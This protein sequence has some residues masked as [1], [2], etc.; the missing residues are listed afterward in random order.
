MRSRFAPH[1][2]DSL[3]TAAPIQNQCRAALILVVLV[4]AGPGLASDLDVLTRRHAVSGHE[5]DA[6]TYIQS[7]VGA[8]AAVDNL[9][10]LTARYGSGSPHTLLIAGLDGP[11]YIVSHIDDSGYLRLQRSADPKPHYD[12]DEFFVGQAV[13]IRTAKAGLVQGVVAA[14]SVHFQK[15]GRSPGHSG[16]DGLYVDIGARSRDEVLRAGVDRLDSVVLDSDLLVLAGGNRVSG[17]W[18]SSL[19]GAAIL[20]DLARQFEAS[21]P[22]EAVTLAFAARQ[23]F[24]HAGLARVLRRAN[25]DRVIYFRPGGGESPGIA[26]AAGWSS[27]WVD[28]LTALAVEAGIELLQVRGESLELGPFGEKNI[29][30]R[31]EHSALLTVGVE[32]A[33]TP[34]EIVDRG[35][36]QRMSRWLADFL[37]S[38]VSRNYPETSRREAAP[39]PEALAPELEL[40]RALVEVPGVSGAEAEVRQ[41]IRRLLPDWARKQSSI[42][43]AGNLIVRLGEGKPRAL[44][45]AHMDEIGF[46]VSRIR[47][48]GSL[49]ADAVG[50]GAAQR[51]A[52]HPILVHG[53]EGSLPGIMT[54]HGTIDIGAESAE[55]AAELGVKPGSTATVPKRF[56]ALARGRVSVRSLDDRVGCAVL[57][58]LLQSFESAEPSTRP[59]RRAVWFVF[60]V[61]EEAGLVGAKAV[62]DRTQPERVYAIDSFVSSDS[63]L[64]NRRIG[65][66]E[67]GDG[68]VI[69]A[70]DNSGISPIQAVRAIADLAR[71]KGIPVQY[72]VT[73]GG[74]DGSRFVTRGAVNIPLSWPLRYAH[75]PV[76]VADPHDI[77]ALYR[78]VAELARIELSGRSFY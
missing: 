22:R 38:T 64:E 68:F 42:D 39:A 69:R 77:E 33:G 63:P 78:I 3:S 45:I 40:I 53:D 44:F 48:D 72:G 47:S 65:F 46:R 56:R 16:V 55:Q 66:A 28:R 19:A 1:S 12:F 2:K 4:S 24:Q 30:P 36:L 10:S 35:R 34:V 11:G 8:R 74:N 52:F 76:E 49:A 18:I 41:A 23:Y 15:S 61:E 58:R 75:T 37:G 14:P 29:W 71:A 25:A 70:M 43:E 26:A 54:R 60:S 27:E 6:L 62:A 57:V 31:P 67:L 32:N 20:L 73:A 5:A 7:V 59:A 17:P 51:F 13:R 50:G 21:P 9:G